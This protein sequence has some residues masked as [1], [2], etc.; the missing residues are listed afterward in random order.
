MA[1]LE[2]VRARGYAIDNAEHEKNIRCLAVPIFNENG[3]IE[4][5]LSAAGTTLDMPDEESIQKAIDR[6][7]EARDKIRMEMGFGGPSTLGVQK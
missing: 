4:A 7:K 6:L 1:E 2:T 3:K 5:A